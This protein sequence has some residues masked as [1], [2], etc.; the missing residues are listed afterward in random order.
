MPIGEIEPIPLEGIPLKTSEEMYM[1][2]DETLLAS[3]NK[4]DRDM[5]APYVLS[6]PAAADSIMSPIHESIFEFPTIH[7]GDKTFVFFCVNGRGHFNVYHIHHPVASGITRSVTFSD[8]VEGAYVFMC[9]GIIKPHTL[10]CLIDFDGNFFMYRFKKILMSYELIQRP[11]A[12]K[13]ELESQIYNFVCTYNPLNETTKSNP[14]SL[15]DFVRMFLLDTEEDL[16]KTWFDGRSGN[17]PYEMLHETLFAAPIQTTDASCFFP[18]KVLRSFYCDLTSKE[19]T[20]IF[21]LVSKRIKWVLKRHFIVQRKAILE[22]KG[23]NGGVVVRQKRKIACSAATNKK[24][25][26]NILL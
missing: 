22:E 16:I 18:L 6:I 14:E 9:D 3:Y 5:W 13:S 24:K 17:V 1:L 23:Q 7:E 10:P 2:P 25:R 19:K 26:S 15:V 20:F 4:V 8:S 12:S 21:K 11:F